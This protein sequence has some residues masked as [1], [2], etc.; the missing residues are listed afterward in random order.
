MN[1][2]KL[3]LLIEI[4]EFAVICT[5]F[6]TGLNQAIKK[7]YKNWNSN[8]FNILSCFVSLMTGF[9]M[10][11]LF[12]DF[13]VYYSIFNGFVVLIGAKSLYSQLDKSGLVSSIKDF[14]K[15]DTIKVDK[16][17]LIKFEGK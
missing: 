16:E 13:N 10:A 7:A 8:F 11:Q 4:V 14:K 2:E 1:Y 12:S 17:N 9:F 3:E 6:S 5:T 15:D